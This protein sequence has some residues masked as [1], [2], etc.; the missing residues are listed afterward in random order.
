MRKN[1]N[2]ILKDILLT[3]IDLSED[4]KPDTVEELYKVYCSEYGWQGVATT[5]TC[6]MWLMGLPTACTVPFYNSEIIEI[7]KKIGLDLSSDNKCHKWC[8]SYWER[9]GNTLYKQFMAA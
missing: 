5:Y 6:K 9:M 1:I 2:K 8:D 4:D 7:G 3:N